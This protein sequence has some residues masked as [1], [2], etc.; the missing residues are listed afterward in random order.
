MNLRI[1]FSAIIVAVVTVPGARGADRLSLTVT[2]SFAFAPADLAVR[3]TVEASGENRAV[4]IIAE[5]GEFYRSSE[6]PLDGEDG[7]RT[8]ELQFRSLP[9][10]SYTVAAVLKGAG[11]E[12]LAELHRVV[13]VVAGEGER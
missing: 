3:T 8:S 1:L 4:E 6:V 9:P 7:P 2:P 13:R 12:P 11:D 10:G 5:S